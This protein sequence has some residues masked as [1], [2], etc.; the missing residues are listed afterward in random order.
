L[1]WVVSAPIPLPYFE[2]NHTISFWD[3]VSGGIH[4]VLTPPKAMGIGLAVSP[5]GKSLL[6]TQI[7]SQGADLHL[8]DGL[9]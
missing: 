4:E 7:E 2:S 9:R 5:D 3:S 6:F 1:D 8:I